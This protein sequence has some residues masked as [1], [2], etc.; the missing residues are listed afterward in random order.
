MIERG[1]EAMKFQVSKRG[2]WENGKFIQPVV[3]IRDGLQY[4]TK[5]Q[6]VWGGNHSAEVAAIAA[7]VA[8]W[9]GKSEG[10]FL[11]MADWAK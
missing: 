2:W 7:E 9:D 6:A 3:E 1:G 8:A 4:A 5:F 11:K 10:R